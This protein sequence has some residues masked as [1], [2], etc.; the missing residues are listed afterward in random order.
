MAENPKTW[1]NNDHISVAEL[2]NVQDNSVNDV[3]DIHQQYVGI[4]MLDQSYADIG[5]P[6]V[7][8]PVLRSTTPDDSGSDLFIS[9][10][11]GNAIRHFVVGKID[12]QVKNT[13]SIDI[14]F[15]LRT[16][17]NSSTPNS[18]RYLIY[19]QVDGAVSVLLGGGGTGAELASSS[20]GV[21]RRASVVNVTMASLSVS[22]T[23]WLQVLTRMKV[24]PASTD[25]NAQTKGLKV[26]R[27]F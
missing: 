11:T 27:K 23:D 4:T 14:D 24:D 19:K 21:F 15:D 3:D 18:V 20:A 7:D 25:N 1:L 13:V 9:L 10:P 12:F 17:T 6:T 26:L 8:E 16:G 2:Q 22:S 5:T